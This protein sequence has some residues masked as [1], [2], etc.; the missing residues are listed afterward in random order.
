MA[1]RKL[2]DPEL[3]AFTLASPGL[4]QT[5]FFCVDM[6]EAATHGCHFRSPVV[7]CS[8]RERRLW[9]PCLYLPAHSWGSCKP[10]RQRMNGVILQANLP[11]DFVHPEGPCLLVLLYE[12]PLQL[13]PVTTVSSV[14]SACFLAL[15]RFHGNVPQPV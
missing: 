8:L 12:A 9:S 3:T 15:G 5:F 14:G 4:P 11:G 10:Y 13:P 1:A 7:S 6:L 2:P